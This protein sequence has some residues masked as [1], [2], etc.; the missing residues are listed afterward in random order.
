[1]AFDSDVIGLGIV[2]LVEA[3]DDV[4]EIAN[5]ADKQQRPS[6]HGHK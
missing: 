6:K 2:A 3:H 4:E 5:P 1:V